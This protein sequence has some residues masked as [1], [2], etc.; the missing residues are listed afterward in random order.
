M[1]ID[2]KVLSE[3]N[4]EGTRLILIENEK[5]TELQAEIASYGKEIEPILN[6][7]DAEYYKVID[8]IRLELN[9]LTEQ[10]NAKKLVISELNKKFSKETEEMDAIGQKA[11]L[12]KNKMTPLI[13]EEVASKLGEFET[14]RNTIVKDGKLYVEVFDEIEEKV[15]ALRASKAKK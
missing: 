14:A 7:L 6:K 9:E 8:P 12:V 4:Y 11:Q 1:Q 2:P 15:K 5:V 13:M 10:V 3:K